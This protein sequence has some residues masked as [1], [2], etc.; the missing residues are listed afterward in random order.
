MNWNA[1]GA[2]VGALALMVGA[3][4][5][6]VIGEIFAAILALGFASLVWSVLAVGDVLARKD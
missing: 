4:A 3:V 1:V 6:V 2:L 5:S